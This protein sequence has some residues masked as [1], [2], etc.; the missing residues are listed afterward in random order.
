VQCTKEHRQ[1]G[2]RV[3][4][5]RGGPWLWFP[6]VAAPG[7]FG[8]RCERFEQ[9]ARRLRI[10]HRQVQE[11][12]G[13]ADPPGGITHVRLACHRQHQVGIRPRGIEIAKRGAHIA[14]LGQHQRLRGCAPERA[15]DLAPLAHEL[16]RTAQIT[17]GSLEHRQIGIEVWQAA[18]LPEVQGALPQPFKQP[19]A[20][21]KLSLKN[22]TTPAIRLGRIT[23]TTC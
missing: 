7:A 1:R 10:T 2:A 14:S 23:M 19:P 12:N 13:R 5:K 6:P 4:A 9:L 15:C 11:P 22:S 20:R 8:G 18:L 16:Q 21:S 3:E 17:P